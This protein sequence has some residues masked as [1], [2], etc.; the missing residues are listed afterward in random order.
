MDVWD[1]FFLGMGGGALP[2]VYALYKLR[3][4]FHRNKPA[5]IT[6]KFYWLITLGMIV[7]GG[8]A[9]VLYLKSGTPLN[10]VLALHLGA[11]TPAM[12]QGFIASKPNIEG[13]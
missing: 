4:D 9:V 6:S 2:E 11:A 7:L 13:A 5:W 12:L 3:E 10:L 1:G 8:L